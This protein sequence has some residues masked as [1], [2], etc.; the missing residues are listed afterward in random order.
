MIYADDGSKTYYHF[1]AHG[2]VVVLTNASGT[3]TKTYSYSAFG[4]EHNPGTYDTN[5]FRYC[6]EY[7][8]AVSGT[9]Y[10]RARY[11]NSDLGRFMQQDGWGFANPEDPL[12]LNLY[13]Y[14][15]NNPIMYF[16]YMGKWPDFVKK[17]GNHLKH[18][19][20][21]VWLLASA[22][23]KSFDLELGVGVGIGHSYKVTTPVG[24]D[25]EASLKMSSTDKLVFDDATFDIR[26]E[27]GIGGS[28]EILGEKIF[29]STNM[30]E[31]S[32]FDEECTCDILDTSFVDKADCPASMPKSKAEVITPSPIPTEIE[33]SRSCY[34][35]VGIEY[36]VAFDFVE[37]IQYWDEAIQYAKSYTMN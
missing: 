6:G 23:I 24:V 27:A 9:I 1:N 8:D 34:Y 4:V 28:F 35:G 16:D 2:D 22:P 13:T 14:C 31:H 18:G 20:T 17:I 11:Y 21:T 15:W 3:K 36:R 32:L 30:H 5:P 7:Y 19:F 12:S 37:C 26:N 25:F 29:D 33:I 10:L